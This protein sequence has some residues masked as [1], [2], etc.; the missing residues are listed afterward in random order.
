MADLEPPVKVSLQY[1]EMRRDLAAYTDSLRDDE[2][3][4]RVWLRREMGP[5]QDSFGDVV[6]FFYDDTKLADDPEACVGVFLHD[7]AEADAVKNLTCAIDAVFDEVGADADDDAYL[8]ARE[9]PQVV[10][11]AHQ[12]ANVLV[13]HPP[14]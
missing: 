10:Q 14:P 7:G 3:Q 4:R 11:M 13:R 9:W 12:L 1:P 2:Y 8:R 6:H 5:Q